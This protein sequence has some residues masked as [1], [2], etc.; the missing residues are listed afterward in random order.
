MTRRTPAAGRSGG[1]RADDGALPAVTP[2]ALLQA[3]SAVQTADAQLRYRLRDRLDLQASEIM[4]V[5]L[6]ERQDAIGQP[7]RS[8]DLSRALGVTNGAASMIVAR[9]IERGFVHRTANPLDGRG[10]HL[11]L[12]A[13]A[14]EA[15]AEAI[16]D[17]RHELQT[18]LADLSPREAKR[19]IVLLT[20][21]TE[22]L[23]G[24]G[25]LPAA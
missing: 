8:I 21:M 14:V 16:G 15:M 25:L 5:E 12:T 24:G 3:V 6:L 13:A 20:A 17:S 1:G 7:V 11:H 23:D 19:V 4:A 22:S 10:H 9:L 2:L 18:L